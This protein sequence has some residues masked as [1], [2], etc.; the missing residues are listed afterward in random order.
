MVYLQG[1]VLYNNLRDGVQISGIRL[2]FREEVFVTTGE[3]LALLRKKRGITQEELS[4]ILNVSRQSVSRWELDAAFPETDKLIKLSKLFECSIDFLLNEDSEECKDKE[5]ETSFDMYYKFVRECGYFFLATSVDNQ[6]RL[7]PMGMIYSNGESLFIAT[8]KRKTV[9]K[10]LTKNPKVEMASYNPN[11][12]KWLR[13]AGEVEAEK[14]PLIKEEMME[15][16]PNLKHAYLYR[17]E[18]ELI[19]YKLL[20][21][22]ISIK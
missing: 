15:A 5:Q 18:S 17:D 9:Y 10:D 7:R 11:N 3:K 16:Y 8:D 2:R 22:E 6:P 4:E 19:I 20:I 12:H 14:S 13:A 21:N 1:K